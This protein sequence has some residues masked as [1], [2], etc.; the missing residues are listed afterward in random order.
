MPGQ[1]TSHVV[2]ACTH[3]VRP[4]LLLLLLLLLQVV[5]MAHPFRLP[6]EACP[7][8]RQC[9]LPRLLASSA[10]RPATGL[11]MTAVATS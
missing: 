11:P 2:D 5:L 6:K 7:G 10:P 1:A 8:T 3:A 4:V 9:V